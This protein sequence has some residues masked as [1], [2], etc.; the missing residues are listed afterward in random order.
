MNNTWSFNVNIINRTEFGCRFSCSRSST[1]IRSKKGY[2]D[3]DSMKIVQMLS[4]CPGWLLPWEHNLWYIR[5]LF[6]SQIHLW[7]ILIIRNAQ[8]I[9]GGC[10]IIER[11]GGNLLGPHAK[12]GWG[13]G[14]NVKKPT[15]WT[16]RGGW[17]PM[18]WTPLQLLGYG[19]WMFTVKGFTLRP[20][21]YSWFT[22][23]L[24]LIVEINV[25]WQS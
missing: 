3:I 2:A 5:T 6:L 7:S 18:V 19:S 20:R 21:L 10:R 8:I 17:G 13:F 14:P 11:G 23:M 24:W 1:S 25:S 4:T 12:V 22:E 16:K 15:S 9:S